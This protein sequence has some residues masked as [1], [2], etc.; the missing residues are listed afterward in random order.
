MHI[1]VSVPPTRTAVSVIHRSNDTRTWFPG[2]SR[3]TC[4]TRSDNIRLLDRRVA[5]AICNKNVTNFARPRVI[6]L[7]GAESNRRSLSNVTVDL[8]AGAA[9]RW[10]SLS[11]YFPSLPFFLS[12]MFLS[13]SSSPSLPLSLS[14]ASYTIIARSPVREHA[15]LRNALSLS[16]HT[17]YSRKN[18][19]DPGLVG[20][21]R[22][23]GILYSSSVGRTRRTFRG[24]AGPQKIS[25]ERAIE[26][27]ITVY[28]FVT[29]IPLRSGF[30]AC[31]D[32]TFRTSTS[33]ARARQP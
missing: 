11:F 15:R 26:F 22:A 18:L 21:S 24:R 31:A 10:E 25:E 9:F 17:L 3:D 27:A 20:E 19:R 16:F 14:L 4:S 7:R 2:S 1:H 23:C 6:P 30:S 5:F 32:D 13:L 29:R 12:F 8:S 33:L 28:I